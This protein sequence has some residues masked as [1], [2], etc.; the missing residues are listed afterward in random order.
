ML[1]ESILF[2]TPCTLNVQN[3]KKTSLYWS[4]VLKWKIW[5]KRIHLKE[6]SCF[7]IHHINVLWS[8]NFWGWV[9]SIE[10]TQSR[11]MASFASARKSP[12][13]PPPHP[14]LSYWGLHT[15]TEQV[16]RPP[17]LHWGWVLS[18]SMQFAVA[19]KQEARI[20]AE[21]S[22]ISV[23]FEAAAASRTYPL[24]PREAT[25]L[26]AAAPICYGKRF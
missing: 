10:A 21:R 1:G 13:V 3:E 25:L 4:Q 2:L 17:R 24:R 6:M 16:E 26:H 23:V 9:F 18:W 11:V 14:L 5:Y 19:P 12:P 8:I 7:M 20:V 15:S 22:L